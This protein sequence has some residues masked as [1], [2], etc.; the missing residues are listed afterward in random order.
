M[1]YRVQFVLAA[2][3]AMLVFSIS[4]CGN[5]VGAGP[6]VR[7]ASYPTATT[8]TNFLGPRLGAH[9]YWLSSSEKNGI[10]YTCAGGHIDISHLRKASD[11]TMFLAAKTSEH[12]GNG[13]T[14]FSF[15]LYEPSRYYVELTY[16]PDWNDLSPES[17]ASIIHDVSIG[18]GEYFAFTA[19]TWH[20]ILSWFGYK[21][22]KIFPEH[23]SAFSWEDSY[24]NLLGTY[25]AA[26][27]LKNIREFNI[28]DTNE[29]DMTM[30]V[31]LDVE[32][33]K[34]GI[35]SSS[36]ARGAAASV[37][38]RWFTGD[39][40]FVDMKKRQFDVGVDDGYVTP[41]ITAPD[42][43]DCS[44]TLPEP[45]PVPTLDFLAKYG[46]SVR[47]ELEAREKV[48]RKILRVVYP[49]IK[50][51]PKRIRPAIHFVRIMDFIEQD[52][53]KHKRNIPDDDEHQVIAYGGSQDTGDR[54]R[55]RLAWETGSDIEDNCP[56]DF[57]DILLTMFHWLESNPC[58]DHI[59]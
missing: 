8:G 37:R 3:I 12:M 38:G 31:A 40:I 43:A 41:L 44:G 15:K 45:Y 56:V 6:R 24:S 57:K 18:L 27:V 4:G 34:L 58:T 5:G 22:T 16:P 10:A 26:N 33:E 49:D 54:R 13:D 1:R 46:F 32:M 19:T 20:E 51:R 59:W 36:V 14:E 55:S 42:I 30:T 2:V 28:R 9:G 17:R 7:C 21:S 35:Q 11:W 29:Y 47:F 48:K 53:I 23:A 52:A 39:L 50:P 25:I